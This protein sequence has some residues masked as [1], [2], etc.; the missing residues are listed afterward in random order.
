MATGGLYYVPLAYAPSSSG[1]PLSG[2]QLFFYLTGTSTPA[3]TYANSTLTTANP[4]PVVANSGGAFP[5]IWLDP[6]VTYK[7][8]LEDQFGVQQ[9]TQDPLYTPAAGGS[10]GL[11][12]LGNIASHTILGNNSGVSGPVA[13]LTAAQV[14]ALLPTFIGDSGSGGTVGLVPAPP[15]GSGAA[16]A[17]LQANGSW[18]SISAILPSGMIVPYVGTAAPAN[19]LLCRGQAISRTT[20]A[21][22]NAL[23]SAV[24]YA[25]PWGVGDGSSTFN[26]PNLQGYFVRGFD[27]SGAIDPSRVF[28]TNQADQGQGHLHGP[29]S[30]SI[31][32]FAQVSSSTESTEAGT[33]ATPDNKFTNSGPPVSD[34][35]NG[36]PRVGLETRPVN[37]ALNYIIKT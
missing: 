16:G 32:Y 24:S 11:G 6:A 37:V 8:V 7:V 30:G 21:A 5:Q 35:T 9:W 29:P 4:N 15:A 23:A 2:A 31:A 17:V 20:Y 28:G 1:A 13:A 36:T 25:A 18:S 33:N 19:W 26:L 3:T 10:G 34:G 14:L 12:G 27:A 22:L